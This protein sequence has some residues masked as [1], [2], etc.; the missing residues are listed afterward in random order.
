MVRPQLKWRST[1]AKADQ[2]IANERNIACQI[3]LEERMGCG[4]GACMVCSCKVK[5][6][7]GFE[8]K[9]VCTDGP[10][11]LSDEVILD[12]NVQFSC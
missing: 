8:Y 3:S 7:D 6:K 11:F 5:M 1:H 12:E 4:I 10:V 9:K 2:S